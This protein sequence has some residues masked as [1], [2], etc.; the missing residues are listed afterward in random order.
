MATPR[1]SHL[2]E[3]LMKLKGTQ[4]SPNE[5]DG[6]IYYPNTGCSENEQN[7]NCNCRKSRCLKLYC[8]CFAARSTCSQNCRC[9]SCNNVPSMEAIRKEAY[10]LIEQRN[11]YAFEEKNKQ[12][13]IIFCG[14]NIYSLKIN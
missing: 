12:V 14:I 6:S 13:P 8:Q 3:I 11:P 1:S 9:V 10:T 4:N 7:E 2:A 5:P